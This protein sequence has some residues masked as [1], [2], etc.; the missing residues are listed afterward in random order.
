MDIDNLAIVTVDFVTDMIMT[1]TD[2]V[3]II[4]PIQSLPRVSAIT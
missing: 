1:D 4:V 2:H 3:S